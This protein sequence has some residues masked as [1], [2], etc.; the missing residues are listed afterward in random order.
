M[1]PFEATEKSNNLEKLYHAFI[2]IKPT[3]VEAER[4]SSA[5]VPL[6]PVVAKRRPANQFD[7]ACEIPFTYFLI[8]PVKYLVHFFKDHVSD[9]TA[10]QQH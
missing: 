7:L 5:T 3:S 6:S 2:T 9:W 10:V 4:A 1:S 8:R